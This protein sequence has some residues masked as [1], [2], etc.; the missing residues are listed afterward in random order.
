MAKR[1]AIIDIGS[2]SIRMVIFEKSSRFAFHLI[3]ESKS[4][5]R[6]S[7]NAY[8]NSGN[9]QD[10]ALT[11]AF[12][13]LK[14]FQLIIKEFKVYKTLIVATSA[15]R[16]APNKK[17][18]ITKVKKELDLAI[19]TIDGD[20]E[21]YLGGLAAAN[22]LYLKNGLT[23][24]IGGGSTELAL[25]KNKKVIKTLS[26]DLGTVRLKELYFDVNN[27]Q[28]AKEHIKKELKKL[29]PEFIC[30]NIIGIG[31]TLRA[32]SKMIIEKEEIVYKKL[33]GF[34]YEIASEKKYFQDILESDF[35]QLKNL[36]VKSERLD[37]I[38]PGLLILSLLIKQIQASKIITSG[39][40]VREGLFLADLLRSQQ[41]KF[42]NNFNPSV[43]S[44]LDRF[45]QTIITSTEAG[46]LFTLCSQSLNI[47]KT[48]KALFLT[49]V[50]LSNIG[51]ELDFYEAHR[52]AYY[53]LLNGLTYG[54]SHNETILIASLVRF[55]R[56]GT[57]SNSHL[58]KYKAY[59][60]E[61]K[62]LEA[63]GFLVRLSQA[64][65]A[66]FSQVLDLSIT[67]KILT[68]KA[69]HNHL[70]KIRL[71]ELKENTFLKIELI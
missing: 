57:I 14:E 42:P 30:E 67:N 39:V 46:K 68:I 11:R 41:D 59:L 5:V 53:L 29:S 6:I 37:I 70:L 71:N 8:E 23:I 17:E 61:E 63:L 45:P 43:H 10:K 65:Y 38:Q 35:D 13:T 69:E 56:K 21:A 66:E 40:G 25:F 51:K 20:K 44:I 54:F 4:R 48:Y 19:K 32:L 9:L 60:P 3:H 62:T 36:G 16:D 15:L 33:H 49:A 24:D 34:T 12:N 26:L 50:K 52:H 47:N 2:N 1:T 27:I 31:G 18:F 7:E 22:L 64:L 28:G 55:Q 58:R